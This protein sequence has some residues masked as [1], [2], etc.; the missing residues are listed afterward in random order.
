MIDIVTHSITPVLLL[1]ITYLGKI[2]LA[3]IDGNNCRKFENIEKKIDEIQ[4]EH[5]AE[6]ELTE[7]IIQLKNIK[8][9]FIKEIRDDNLR[10]AINEVAD[11]LIDT[12]SDILNI[13]KVD[14]T[15]LHSIKNEL[16]TVFSYS[17]NRLIEYVG[18]EKAEQIYNLHKPK[19]KIFLNSVEDILTAP[20][21]SY[22]EKF[23]I[24]CAN[25][26]KSFLQDIKNV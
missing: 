18:R 21:N 12:I 15:N 20:N 10:N 16:K 24:L 7:N 14:I 1:V 13:Y 3:K 5:Q 2:Y 25:Y 26:L 8:N 9:Y 23:I 6:R 19:W 11:K 17:R 4:R 22:T